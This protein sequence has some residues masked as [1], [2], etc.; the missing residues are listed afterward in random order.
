MVCLIDRKLAD[1]FFPHQNPL[2]QEIA[3]YKGWARIVGVTAAV[4]ADGLEEETRPVVYYSLPQITFFARAAVVVRSRVPSAGLIR[5]TVRQANSSVPVFDLQTIEERM[6]EKLGIRRVLA[7]LLAIFGSISLLL[8]T[9]G[10]YG[11]I[12]Q[13]V[14]ERTQ[15]IG[16]RMALGARPDQILRRFMGQGLRAAG[17]GLVLGAV[18]TIY[19]QNWISGMLYQVKALDAATLAVSVAAIVLILLFAVWWPARRASRID[20]Q[21]ALRYE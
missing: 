6:G 10:I 19:I 7:G 4:R 18:T 9:I 8:A 17:L 1:R 2:G 21:I 15:E 20:P 14:S 12:A 5:D 3:M 16:V 11:V 13:V